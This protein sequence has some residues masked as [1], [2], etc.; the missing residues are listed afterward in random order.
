[1]R[2]RRRAVLATLFISTFALAVSIVGIDVVCPVCGEKNHFL[3]YATYGSYVYRNP[4]RFQLVYWPRND[5]LS[6]YSC[7]RCHL[8]LWSWDFRD[9]DLPEHKKP[10]LRA[11]ADKVHLPAAESYDQIPMSARLT[12]AEPMYRVL[13]K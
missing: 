6:L 13:D 5:S 11:A 4:S 1:M 3:A 9:K 7:K 10:L 12:A 8:T 2:L